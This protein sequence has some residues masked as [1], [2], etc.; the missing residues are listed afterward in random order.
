MIWRT[1]D[2]SYTSVSQDASAIVTIESFAQL[3]WGE[4]IECW[5]KYGNIDGSEEDDDSCT[6]SWRSSI[7]E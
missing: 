2:M 7:D 6:K 1:E 5:E 3:N 4:R